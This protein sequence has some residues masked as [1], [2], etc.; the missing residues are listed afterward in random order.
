VVGAICDA[1]D[2]LVP[3][4]SRSSHRELISFVPDRPGHDFRYAIDCSKLKTELGWSA[5][6]SFEKG[7]YATVQWYIDNPAWWRPLLAN[8]DVGGRRGLSKMRA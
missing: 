8:S 1:M 4:R 6:Q 3:S 7:L 5:Q 2:T